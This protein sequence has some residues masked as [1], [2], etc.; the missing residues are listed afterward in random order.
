MITWTF[1]TGR[2]ERK[3]AGGRGAGADGWWQKCP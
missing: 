2:V 1:G 3:V